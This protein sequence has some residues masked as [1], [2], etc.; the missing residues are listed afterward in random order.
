ALKLIT[1]FDE[2]KVTVDSN[3]RNKLTEE[4]FRVWAENM[5]VIP[6]LGTDLSVVVVK[7]NFRNVPEKATLGYS[8]SSPGYLNP[9]QFFFRH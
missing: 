4:M 6:I 8:Y 7:E 9:E 5:W 3:T 2:I 1:I